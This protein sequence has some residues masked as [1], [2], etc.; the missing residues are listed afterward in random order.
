MADDTQKP[1]PMA[2]TEWG[3]SAWKFLHACS[4]AFPENPTRK[5][6]QS[7]LSVLNN[8]GDILPC[9]VCREHY[10]DNI[11]MNPPRVAN[12]QEFSQWL[13]ELHNAVNRS[14]QQKEVD[15]ESVRRHY[16]DNTRELD[17]DCPYTR[18]LKAHLENTQKTLNWLTIAAMVLLVV[19]VALIALRSR[20]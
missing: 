6:R 5:Q 10:T 1:H 9:P 15:F 14:R 3:R 4:F 16:E 2:P 8:L 7:A 13:V 11:A 17:C 12:K 18:K 20:K 19:I